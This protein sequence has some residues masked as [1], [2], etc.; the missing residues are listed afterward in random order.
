[1]AG[2]AWCFT[3]AA[4]RS[5]SRCAHSIWR[6]WVTRHG[7]LSKE[8]TSVQTRT[9]EATPVPERSQLGASKA[10]GGPRPARATVTTFVVTSFV[11][12]FLLFLVQ[13]IVA[14]M[15][16]PS[17]GGTASVWNTAMVFFQV[18]L[19]AGYALAHGAMRRLAPVRQRRLQIAALALAVL[20]L[21]VAIPDWQP[22]ASGSPALWT[23]A[24]L[25]LAV[26]A[27]FLMLATCSPT[28]QH[29]F[30]TSEATRGRDP[31]FL[32]AAGNAGSLLALV[33]YPLL[34]EPRLTLDAQAR[35]FT[36][37]YVVLVGLSAVCALQRV[38]PD[39]TATG[40]ATTAPPSG[41][42]T[43]AA[44]PIGW[45]RRGRWIAWSAIPSALLLGVTRHLSTDV[46]SVPMLWIVPLALYLLTFIIAFGRDSTTPVKVAA[47]GLTLTVIPL[48]LTLL[49]G[50]SSLAVV[51]V[52]NLVAFFFAA[53]LGHGRLACDRPPA[54]DLTEFYLWI[55]IGGALGGA[56]TAL[57]A[58]LVFPTVIEYPLALAAALAMVPPSLPARTGRRIDIRAVLA[59]ALV[60]SV[61]VV[62]ARATSA[63]APDRLQVVAVLVGVTGFLAY[64][65]ARTPLAFAGAMGVLALVSVVP[66]ADTLT[67]QRSFFGVSAVDVDPEGRHRLMNGTTAHGLQD[68]EG[69]EPTKPLTYYHPD[70]PLGELM[71]TAAPPGSWDVGVV[72]L[73]A[74]SLASYGRA[75]DTFTFYEIDPVVIG[76]AQ[77]VRYFTYLSETDAEV[78]IVVGDGR[79]SLEG[80]TRA[81]DV[82]VLDAFSSDSIPL[83][84]LTEEALRTYVDHLAPDGVL[85]VHISN[86]YFDLEP[87]LARLARE[88]GL[89][90]VVGEHS[91]TAAQA[92][93]GDS[94]QRWVFIARDPA[95]LSD[96]AARGDVHVLDPDGRGPRWTDDFS[97]VLSALNGL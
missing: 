24:V 29:W 64:R 30:A 97:N 67:T 15:L 45:A 16:L 55:S 58:P 27:P 11:G 8:M 93:D 36:V 47:R 42:G 57:V 12:S 35:L 49:V 91:P 18:T 88:L 69:P 25:A 61:A 40:A 84:L 87:G 73:G 89:V 34:I 77:D 19:V 44:A 76:L 31:Y 66:S 22:P 60:V 4:E 81:H 95:A 13:P 78:E 46:V 23:L 62:A 38:A 48:T 56:T 70:G 79:L 50:S 83:H 6:S 10:T 43:S 41:S 51:F 26:G 65:F 5:M 59:V 20:A 39:A 68:V 21:P 96:V 54:R 63:D 86:R 28:V 71:S 53:L 32:Y 3:P 75:G 37:G 94:A 33:A 7:P 82:L 2:T 52:L 90:G 74:G 92:A 80:S 17:L 72:G 85:A 9:R 14:K 1:M